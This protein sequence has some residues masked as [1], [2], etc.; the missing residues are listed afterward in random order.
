MTYSMDYLNNEPPKEVQLG[1]LLAWLVV[2]TGLCFTVVGVGE[3]LSSRASAGLG[4]ALIGVGLLAYSYAG[5][6]QAFKR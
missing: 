2:F 4:T 5:F 6:R 1:C 3:M